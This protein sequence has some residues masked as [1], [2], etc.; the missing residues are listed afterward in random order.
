[1]KNLE[2][3]AYVF[4]RIFMLANRLQALGDRLDAT[5][6]VKQWLMIAIIM[7]S[8]GSPSLGEIAGHMGNSR[9]NT[10]KMAVILQKQGFL[11][12]EQDPQDRRMVRVTV[13][14]RCRDYF[15]NREERE[16]RFIDQLFASL[17]PELLGAVQEGIGK[18]MTN[19]ADMEQAEYKEKP[20]EEETE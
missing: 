12:V 8:G 4:S 20:Y 14:E 16:L 15:R 7:R 10:K 18:L 6:T 19:L 1:L 3:K 13:T 17:E 2:N 11:Q 9:Q 5:I